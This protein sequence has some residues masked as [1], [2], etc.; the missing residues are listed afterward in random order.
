MLICVYLVAWDAKLLEIPDGSP[1]GLAGGLR[2]F[3]SGAHFPEKK[4]LFPKPHTW[5]FRAVTTELHVGIL[6]P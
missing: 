2:A 5:R 6:L 4:A 3:H 1:W